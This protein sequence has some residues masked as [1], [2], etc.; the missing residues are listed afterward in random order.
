MPSRLYSDSATGRLAADI[1][2]ADTT[3]LLEPGQGVNFPIPSAGDWAILTLEDVDGNKEKVRQT[4][5]SG[6]ELTVERAQEGTTARPFV[7][8]SRCELRLTASA[9]NDLAQ[10]NG[11]ESITGQWSFALP[12]GGIGMENFARKD[13]DE[14]IV[15]EWLFTGAATFGPTT[16][17]GPMTVN[18]QATFNSATTFNNTTNLNGTVQGAGSDA[19]GRLANDE[20]VTGQWTFDQEPVLP[21]NGGGLIPP[22]SII[23]FGG[24]AAPAGWLACNGAAVS[25]T[26][27][28][29]LF[30]AIGE[31][32]GDG[33]GSTTF[34][35]PDLTD[36]FIRGSGTE[37]VGTEEAQSLA[38]HQH[39]TPSRTTGGGSVGWSPSTWPYGVAPGVGNITFGGGGGANFSPTTPLNSG[40]ANTVTGENRPA[41][42]RVLFIIKT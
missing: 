23:S 6:D 5:R 17:G 14:E 32:W 34:N 16:F 12:P 15:G 30:A 42:K 1:T 4:A 28:A 18:A 36:E 8:G 41:N 25:R 11:D 19:F 2:D 27:Y 3:I 10:V 33:D 39:A 29:G 38:D 13:F 21:S 40:P 7:A 22:G 20:T 24:V 35:L 37:P 26:T 31:T 9:F